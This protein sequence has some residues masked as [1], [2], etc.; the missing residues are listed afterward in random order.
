MAT[1]NKATLRDMVLQ[2]LGALGK[3]Q[4]ADP[5]DTVLVERAIDSAFE[6]LQTLGL[7]DYPIAAVPEEMQF[8]LRDMVAGMLVNEYGLV[9]EGLG[10]V[11]R[12]A[13]TAEVRMRRERR[14]NAPKTRAK[15]EYF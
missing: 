9:G 5:D 7:G 14:S 2:S 1:I 15:P 4:G 3:G 12:A 11:L 13:S 10:K 8:P 6:S